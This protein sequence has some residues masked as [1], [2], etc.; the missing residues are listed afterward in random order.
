MWIGFDVG[1]SS[2]TGVC[3]FSS[4]VTVY[5]ASGGHAVV[6]E[7]KWKNFAE[8]KAQFR[9]ASAVGNRIVFNIAGN[10]YRLVVIINYQAQI[11]FVRFV[12]T[13]KEYDDLDV[14]NA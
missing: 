4:K 11:A 7:A 5:F 9:N 8:V 6:K 14:K 1:K 3:S 12:G 10:K 13:H 2:S